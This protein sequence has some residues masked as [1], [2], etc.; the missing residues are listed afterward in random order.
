MQQLRKAG[1][2][3]G[4][5]DITQRELDAMHRR[6]TEWREFRQRFQ[7]SQNNLAEAL[8]ISR[9]SVIYIEMAAIL[10]PSAQT[11]RNFER[12]RKQLTDS[13]AA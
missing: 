13:E 2:F 9:R 7:Y 10:R 11:L 8:G 6:S 12:L 1:R 3:N 4:H 5:T